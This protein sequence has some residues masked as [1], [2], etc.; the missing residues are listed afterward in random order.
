MMVN[1]NMGL[2]RFFQNYASEEQ[3]IEHF[4][5]ERQ[6]E[7]IICTKCSCQTKHYYIK[8]IRQ[9]RCS[10]CKTKKGLRKDSYMEFSKLPLHYWYF[11]SY[12]MTNFTK[13]FS[14]KEIQKQIGHKFYQ[15]IFEMMHK[16]RVLMGQRDKIYTLNYEIEADE[17]FVTTYKSIKEKAESPKLLMKPVRNNTGRGSDRKTPILVAVESQYTSNDNKHKPNKAVDFV[18]LESLVGTGSAELNFA[19]SNMINGDN[20]VVTTDFWS[21]MKK[22]N[23]IAQHTP[24]NTNV[25]L[26]NDVIAEHLPWVHKIISNFKR[27]VLNAHHAISSKYLDNYLAEFQYKFNRRRFKVRKFEHLLSAGLNCHAA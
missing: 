16:V 27:N 4:V 2:I 11:T 23:Q 10:E 20:A 3:C 22:V 13:S 9:F 26:K 25:A 14:A 17:G 1:E 15:P 21:G 24:I 19:L 12:M 18:R 6:N 5:S 7:G 8:S